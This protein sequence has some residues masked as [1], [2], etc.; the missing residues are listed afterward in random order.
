LGKKWRAR[1]EERHKGSQTPPPPKKNDLA[2]SPL[3]AKILYIFFRNNVM[4]QRNKEL[5]KNL[6]IPSLIHS[7]GKK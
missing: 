4:V 2:I 5:M 1:E 3:V 7:P 6:N